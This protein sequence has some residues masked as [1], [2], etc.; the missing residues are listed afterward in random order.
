MCESRECFPHFFG[1]YIQE[2]PC[3]KNLSSHQQKQR[4]SQHTT[5]RITKERMNRNF[6][7]F[8][9]LL[10]AGVFFFTLIWRLQTKHIQGKKN[11]TSDST[12]Q[13]KTLCGRLN[14]PSYDTEIIFRILCFVCA[15]FYQSHDRISHM[16][17][18]PPSHFLCTHSHRTHTHTHQECGKTFLHR[19]SFHIF[20]W[21]TQQRWLQNFLFNLNCCHHF[22]CIHGRWQIRRGEKMSPSE[23]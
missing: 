15:V 3:M 21:F 16:Y 8:C 1:F 5:A 9:I 17:K 4:Q 19:A 12:H 22:C 14:V 2:N 7:T 20:W 6:L 10:Q 18:H 13:L 11:L 23:I